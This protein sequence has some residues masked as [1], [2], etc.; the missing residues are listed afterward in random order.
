M[1]VKILQSAVYAKFE[2]DKQRAQALEAGAVADFP[3]WYAQG[4]IDAGLAGPV[5][6][7]TVAPKRKRQRGK[8]SDGD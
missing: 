8:V 1:Q 6:V 7:E 2:P 3:E 4:L 5:E